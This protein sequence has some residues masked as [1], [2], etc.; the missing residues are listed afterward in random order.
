MRKILNRY[1][2]VLWLLILAVFFVPM[3][4]LCAC[5]STPATTEPVETTEPALPENIVEA[6]PLL[7]RVGDEITIDGKKYTAATLYGTDDGRVWMDGSGVFVVN[8]VNGHVY[9]V[10]QSSYSHKATDGRLDT[11][12]IYKGVL[13]VAGVDIQIPEIPETN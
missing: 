10:V 6:N 9:M 7:I 13:T 8:R 11:G 5:S 3:F 4:T 12:L 1:P 2:V